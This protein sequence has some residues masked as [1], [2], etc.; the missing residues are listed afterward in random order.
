MSATLIPRDQLEQV[1][2]R[3]RL[4]GEP[5]RLELLNL[6]HTHG[7]LHVQALV[8]ASGLSQANVSKHLRLLMDEGLVTRRQEGL[9]SFYR[10]DDP[11]LAA[12]CLLVCGRL[13]EAGAS[14]EAA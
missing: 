9:Y 2:R 1:A 3:F 4:L 11:M 14:R 8:E 10:I 5:A 12:L 6:L 13:A 7:E